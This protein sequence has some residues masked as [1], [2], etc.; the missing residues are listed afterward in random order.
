M[1]FCHS[2]LHSSC[3]LPILR[4][5]PLPFCPMVSTHQRMGAPQEER[6]NPSGL[7]LQ[8]SSA[9]LGSAKAHAATTFSQF[10]A[11]EASPVPVP[12][13]QPVWPPW[14][15]ELVNGNHHLWEMSL[16]TLCVHLEGLPQMIES[17]LGLFCPLYQ[18]TPH[19]NS[20]LAWEAALHQPAIKGRR[21]KCLS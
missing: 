21:F 20:Y 18:E 17:P 8:S 3:Q 2:S 4:G 16:P 11:G 19:L 14:G 12:A 9:L 7:E 10:R 15:L 5:D 1:L 13:L 6:G